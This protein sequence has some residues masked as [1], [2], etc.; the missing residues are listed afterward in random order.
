MKLVEFKS[1]SFSGYGKFVRGGRVIIN[2]DQVTA[3]HDGALNGVTTIC[4]TSGNWN[5]EESV[6]EAIEKLTK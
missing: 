4:T 2:A 3:I 1:M 5:V 6:D